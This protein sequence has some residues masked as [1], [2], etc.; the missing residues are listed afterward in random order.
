MSKVFD[1]KSAVL[2]VGGRGTKADCA[3]IAGGVTKAYYDAAVI[4]DGGSFDLSRVMGAN[5]AIFGNDSGLSPIAQNGINTD[6][7]FDALGLEAGMCVFLSGTDVITDG[8]HEVDSVAGTNVE[9]TEAVFEAEGGGWAGDVDITVGGGFSSITY[10]ITYTDATSYDQWILTNLDEVRTGA[11]SIG[12]GGNLSDNTHLHIW[13]YNT[14]PPPNLYEPTGDMD[15]NETTKTA[16]TYYV[17]ALDI[18]VNGSVPAGKKVVL[19]GNGGSFGIFDITSGQNIHFHNMEFKGV[20]DTYDLFKLNTSAKGFGWHGCAFTATFERP[21][22]GTGGTSM[23]YYDCYFDWGTHSNS[24]TWGS[25]NIGGLFLN[26][27]FDLDGAS[28]YLLAPY[29]AFINCLIIGGGYGLA[30]FNNVVYGCTF[31]KQTVTSIYSNNAAYCATAIINNIV[32]PA[33]GDND[34][35]IDLTNGSINTFMNNCYYGALATGAV[36]NPFDKEGGGAFTPFGGGNK[37]ANPLMVDPENDDFRLKPTSPCLNT[38]IKLL[39][40]GFS[41]IGAWL[42]KSFLGVR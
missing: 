41:T 34:F 23:F 28:S 25:S 6:T 17:S 2:F 29:A 21:V 3:T 5:G 27:V 7:D 14:V 15:Y 33:D 38:G 20:A 24:L 31:Y 30:N 4:A 8:L 19:D 10:T 26:C 40:D 1:L 35:V 42:R 39:G 9:F 36:D 37:S 22:D 12:Q 16:G 18:K 11:I 13:G 32:I